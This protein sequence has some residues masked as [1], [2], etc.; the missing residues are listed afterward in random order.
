MNDGRSRHGVIFDGEYFIVAGGY[1]GASNNNN[2]A[3]ERC[4][5][6]DTEESLILCR[7]QAP[8]LTN[9]Q[10]YPELFMVP[11]DYCLD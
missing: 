5:I 9:Y 8:T 6:V 11:N 10:T 1:N 7:T 2:V 4:K 3:T